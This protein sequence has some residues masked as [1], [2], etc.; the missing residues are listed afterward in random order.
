MG[1]RSKQSLGP[2]SLYGVRW[3]V[4]ES[5]CAQWHC[6]SD[7]DGSGT[8]MV[9]LAPCTLRPGLMGFRPDSVAGRAMGMGSVTALGER[10]H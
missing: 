5:A 3:R 7:Q 1:Y 4:W 2:L 6:T 8:P 9:G 10:R